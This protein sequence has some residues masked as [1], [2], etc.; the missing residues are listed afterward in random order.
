MNRFDRINPN[1][2]RPF[3]YGAITGCYHLVG[4]TLASLILVAMK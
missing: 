2:P 3:L 4:I 1:I